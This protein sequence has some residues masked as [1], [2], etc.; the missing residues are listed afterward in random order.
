MVAL[1]KDRS[2]IS[3]VHIVLGQP[4]APGMGVTGGFV[5]TEN[6][7][8]PFLTSDAGIASEPETVTGAGFCPAG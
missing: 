1:V 6:A 8:L 7:T 4:G 2:V 3:S 5:V